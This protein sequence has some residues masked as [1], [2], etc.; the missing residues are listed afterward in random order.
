MITTD[1]QPAPTLHRLAK[2]DARLL[3]LLRTV[4]TLRPSPGFCF[5]TFSTDLMNRVAVIFFPGSAPSRLYPD[6]A[7]T[8]REPLGTFDEAKAVT[9]ELLQFVPGCSPRCACSLD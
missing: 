4:R 9:A 5:S 6:L 3:G 8:R 1:R 2:K 7:T